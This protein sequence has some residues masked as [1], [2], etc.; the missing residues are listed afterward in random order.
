M[1]TGIGL[2]TPLGCS[3][4]KTWSAVRQ[5]LP[6]AAVRNA[7]E[8]PHDMGLYVRNAPFVTPK[9]TPR[10]FPIAL[11]AAV[12]ALSQAG[13]DL[14]NADPQ[15]VGCSVSV[16]K[17]V[18][19]AEGSVLFHPDSV[20]RFLMEKLR[21]EGPAQNLVAACA[22]GIHSIL[23]GS[24]WLKEGL[25]DAVL[26][27]SCE[28]SLHPLTISGFKNLGVLSKEPR[29]FDIRRD[30]FIM[31]EGAGILVLERADDARARGAKILAE[32]SGCAVGSD[33]EH[34]VRFKE[35]GSSVSRVM[36][37]ALADADIRA[38]EIGY[39][40][41]HGTGTAANDALESRAVK[42]VFSSGAVKTAVS[43]TKGSTGH[44]LGA[45][46]SVEAGLSCLALRDGFVPP[47]AG[48]EQNDPRCGLDY[49]PG[50]GI[51]KEIHHVL[52]LS[53]GFGGP[54]GA[55]V[56]SRP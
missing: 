41:L 37:R 55:V 38:E 28:S 10:I 1:V 34:P 40:N 35:D 44:L 46:G 24:R 14:D 21:L 31:G 29:P 15:R 56:L 50:R 17:P 51:S 3:R 11:S 36:A 18:L 9:G 45:A 47:T 49:T 13:L 42:L 5:G 4:E 20:L 19:S 26:A 54:I 27:G 16:S 32:V 12:E 52:S 6:V 39:I 33:S 48:L 2:I 43:S 8:F 22:T 53:F 25:A 30:G 23:L 7:E